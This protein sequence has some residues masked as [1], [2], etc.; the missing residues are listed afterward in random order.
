VT[1]RHFIALAEIVSRAGYLGSE[2]REQ[3][4][5]D[6]VTLCADANPRFG[7]SRFRAACEPEDAMA[8]LERARAAW[9]RTS[10]QLELA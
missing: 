5:S 3:L 2:A 4:V 8:A 7:P 10:A 1:K 9:R 6:L